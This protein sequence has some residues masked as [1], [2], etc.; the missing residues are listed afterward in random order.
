MW[1]YPETVSSLVD[2][3]DLRK[4]N[5]VLAGDFGLSGAG[6]LVVDLRERVRGPPGLPIVDLRPAVLKVLEV[7]QL[8]LL[9]RAQNTW[10]SL[11]LWQRGFE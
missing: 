8:L 2:L 4:Q 3:H 6:V 9:H 5:I 10:A 11:R 7:A 1:S